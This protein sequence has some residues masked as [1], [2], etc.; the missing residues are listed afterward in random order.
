MTLQAQDKRLAFPFQ[1]APALGQPAS[2]LKGRASFRVKNPRLL[3]FC[4]QLRR[5]L[6]TRS[7]AKHH[8]HCS[9][10]LLCTTIPVMA[11]VGCRPLP[12]PSK[13]Q[14]SY[15]IFLWWCLYRSC[16]RAVNGAEEIAL[17]SEC[18]DKEKKKK[19]DFFPSSSRK[20][21]LRKFIHDQHM[22]IA[23]NFVNGNLV[24]HNTCVGDICSGVIQY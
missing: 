10:C 2:A 7:S 17:G 24:I 5:S 21:N 20:G 15:Q 12:S 6:K 1:A 19:L 8:Y 22:A 23:H 14:C 3:S 9:C 18:R 16:C 13:E 4:L 11:S